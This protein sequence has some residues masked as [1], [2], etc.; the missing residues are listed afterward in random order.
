ME[1]GMKGQVRT[2]CVVLRIFN[3]PIC[4]AD[5]RKQVAAQPLAKE[6]FMDCGNF[7]LAALNV[8]LIHFLKLKY[9]GNFTYITQIVH[10]N[11]HLTLKT[12]FSLTN[13]S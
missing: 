2:L 9:Y 5:M 12:L 13:H 6:I 11:A 1:V 7:I 3:Q 4:K 8:S 10:S